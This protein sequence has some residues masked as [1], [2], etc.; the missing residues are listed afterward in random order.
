MAAP[1]LDTLRSALRRQMTRHNKAGAIL[2][3]LTCPC[4]A[5]MLMILLAGTAVG[6]WLAAVKAYLY[7]G[8]TVLFMIGLWLMVRRNTKACEI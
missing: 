5:A 3:M 1:M 4:H 2:V 6:S 8:F 7:L